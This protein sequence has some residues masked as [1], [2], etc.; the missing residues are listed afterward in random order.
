M[1]RSIGHPRADDMLAGSAL[2]HG[3]TATSLDTAETRPRHDGVMPEDAPVE[4]YFAS[5]VLDSA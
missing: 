5:G 2:V 4:W 1:C 3:A